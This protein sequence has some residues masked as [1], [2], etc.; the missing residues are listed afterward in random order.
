VRGGR[1]EPEEPRVPSCAD[2]LR[3]HPPSIRSYAWRY[4][5]NG[6]TL[7]PESWRAFLR[8]DAAREREKIEL[9]TAI[10]EHC[11]SELESRGLEYFVLLFHGRSYA[12]GIDPKDW[13]EELLLDFL[14]S[15]SVPFVSS[16]LA[17][18]EEAGR[19]GVDPDLFYGL[20]GVSK[21]HLTPLGNEIVFRALEKGIEHRYDAPIGRFRLEGL[22]AAN[23]VE[24]RANTRDAHARFERGRR[25]RFQGDD[26]QERLLLQPRPD[27]ATQISYALQRRATRFQTIVK[28]AP[29][30][31]E[32][33]CGSMG[34]AFH[35]DG[36]TAIA[37]EISPSQPELPVDLDLCGKEVLVIDVDDAGDGQECDVLYLANPRFR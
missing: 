34:I 4:L 26:T 31:I 3:D 16:K 13:R 27:R 24:N 14:A 19:T 15:R 1:L 29:G 28:L 23:F 12:R 36:V 11:R 9:N 22:S 6:S 10:L 35:V 18:L 8:G 17:L 21:D 25:E 2:Y 32:R 30:A 5:L 33:Q 7:L 37:A 20:D